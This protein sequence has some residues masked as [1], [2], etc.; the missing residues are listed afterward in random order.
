VSR[1][2]LIDHALSLPGASPGVACAG[3][4]LERATAVVK[5][6]AFVFVGDTDVR[7]KLKESLPEARALAASSPDR[8][9]VGPHG[10]VTVRFPPGQPPDLTAWIEESWRLFR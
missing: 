6:K 2:G 4:A 1:A 10:W 8:Y 9:A 7:L 3:T 5:K